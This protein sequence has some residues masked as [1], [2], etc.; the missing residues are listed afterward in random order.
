MTIHR[1]TFVTSRILKFVFFLAFALVAHVYSVAFAA[2]QPYAYV[3]GQ[4]NEPGGGTQLLSVVDRATGAIVQS[5]P[6]GSGCYCLNPDS[7]VVSTDGA[8]VYVTNEL[9]NSVS[10]IDTASRTVIGTI[11]VGTGPTAVAVHPNGT[12]LYVLNGSGTT[13]VSVI[14]TTTNAV[15]ATIPLTVTQAR[16]MAITPNGERLY[17]STYSANT[18]KVIDTAT[19]AIITTIGVG[20][21]PVGIDVAP[22][23]S[24]VY[25]AAFSQNAVSIVSTASNTLVGTVGVGNSPMSARVTPNGA[26]VYAANLGSSTVSVIDTS[27]RTV[28]ATI[29]VTFNPRTLEFNDDGTRAFVANDLNVQTIDTST[30]TV[31]HTLSFDGDSNG[32]PA[33]IAIPAPLAVRSL[34]ANVAFPV[35]AGTSVTWTAVAT[36]GAS[37]YSFKFWIHD[38]STWTVGQDWSASNS[39]NW[40]PVR[41]GTYNVQVWARN[42]GSSAD[43]DAWSTAGPVSVTEPPP[44]AVTALTSNVSGPVRTSTTVTWSATASGGTGPYSYRFLVFNGTSWSVGRE[45]SSSNTW[46]WTP[47][48]PGTYNFQVW[49]RNAGSGAEY[50]AWRGTQP[51]VVNGPAP[52]SVTSLTASQAFPLPAGTPVS[53]AAA[54]SGGTGPYTY[55]FWIYNGTTWTVGRDWGAS[56]AFT[57]LP[58]SPGT[59]SFQ[60]WARNAGSSANYDAFGAFGPYTVT[61]PAALTVTSLLA[62][63]VFPVP[64]GTPVIWTASARGGTGPYTFKFLVYNGSTWTIAQDWG[65][66]STWTWVP[67]AAGSYQFQVWVRNAGSLNSYDAWIGAGPAAIGP[68]APLSITSF[69]GATAPIVGTPTPL[70]AAAQGGVGPY[71]YKFWVHNGSV[72]S[73]GQEWSDASTFSWVPP[74]TGSYSFQVWVR[75][76]GSVTNLDAWRA[77]GPITVDP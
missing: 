50:D 59:Y 22:D 44:I 73:V 39:W 65:P 71:T 48:N 7:V 76:A 27:T 53:L 31:V 9:T 61:A 40:T 38:G 29:P 15:I 25:V 26:R 54:A 21:A 46:S 1:R 62:D 32:H 6:V 20:L 69:S 47:M 23:G 74:A 12:R 75:N 49:V 8:R 17:V 14:N 13:S 34:T 42:A 5:I 4:Q 45:W 24:H 68:S 67:P 11:P 55:K 3:V 70:T 56:N 2:A 30:N 52:L 41:S 35:P 19:N 51:F 63:R 10:V 64:A 58:S 36:S 77:L 18:L 37:P 60:V 57:W 28:V 72:W 66:S 33:A 16:G 43:Y